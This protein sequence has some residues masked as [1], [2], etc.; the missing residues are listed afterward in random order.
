MDCDEPV[1]LK[2]NKTAK[3]ELGYGCLKVNNN[4]AHKISVLFNDL[5]FFVQMGGQ[6][7]EDVE[8]TKVECTV[9]PGIECHGDRK[10][11]RDGIPCV[12]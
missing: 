7:Y 8:K 9:L 3:E 1:D 4:D 5:S 6:R 11:Y 12:K 10:F 2:G